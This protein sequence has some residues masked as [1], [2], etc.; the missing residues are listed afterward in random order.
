LTTGVLTPQ[1]SIE[2]GGISAAAVGA[3]GVAV[4]SKSDGTVVKFDPVSGRCQTQF[5]APEWLDG[6]TI[7]PNG[8]IVGQSQATS[9]G[10]KQIYQFSASG[11]VLSKVALVGVSSLGG[12]AYAPNGKVYGAGIFATNDVRWFELT[13]STGSVTVVAGS[14]Q[15]ALSEVCIDSAGTAYGHSF[16]VLYL[17]T[18][19]TG[20]LLRTLTLQRD[21]GLAAV[22]CR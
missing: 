7:A 6:L 20:A 13:P 18:A 15:L 9:F 19:S 12:I 5:T 1:T 11:A 4:G 16:G 3:D 14:N 8:T 17:Y 10:A 2:C 21:L 22:V